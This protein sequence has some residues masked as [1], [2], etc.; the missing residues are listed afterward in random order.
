MHYEGQ[1]F[2]FRSGHPEDTVAILCYYLRDLV[3]GFSLFV[4]RQSHYAA[5]DGLEL[6]KPG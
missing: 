3:W 1:A 4:L 2:T 5:L 6:C